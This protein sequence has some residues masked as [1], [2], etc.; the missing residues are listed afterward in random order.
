MS[1]LHSGPELF[2]DSESFFKGVEKELKSYQKL[3]SFIEHKIKENAVDEMVNEYFHYM[4]NMD[5]QLKSH[6]HE[7]SSKVMWKIHL[8][9]P[10]TYRRDCFKRFGRVITPC[11]G[12]LEFNALQSSDAKTHQTVQ[13]TEESKFSDL[14]LKNSLFLHYEFIQKILLIKEK[15]VNIRQWI[16]NY[17]QFMASIG[18]RINKKIIIKP[19]IETDL[20]W[21]CH[22]LFPA[23]Y[24]KESLVLANGTFV[25]HFVDLE[26]VQ[27]KGYVIKNEYVSTHNRRSIPII[28]AS[29]ILCLSPWRKQTKLLI[30]WVYYILYDLVEF[31][32]R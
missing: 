20:I 30:P 8:L 10:M 6:P 23:V 15:D 31:I 14:D 3:A 27:H 19:T 11:D 7:N 29:L 5:S 9:H 25:R 21:H 24:C 26:S 4:N 2:V 12:D 18:Q 28:I 16:F 1:L 22:M 13:T 17:K 32:R